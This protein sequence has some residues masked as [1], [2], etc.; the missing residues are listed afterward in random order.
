[1]T[2]IYADEPKINVATLETEVSCEDARK[3]V[4]T[5]G[6][7]SPEEGQILLMKITQCDTKQWNTDHP[8]DPKVTVVS[9]SAEGKILF[10]TISIKDAEK[11]RD[12]AKVIAGAT[13]I[14]ELGASDPLTMTI[15]T[16][17]GDYTVDAYFDAAKKSDPLI[18]VFPTLIPGNKLTTDAL[19][20]LKLK[21]PAEVTIQ[22]TE[23]HL[24]KH[25][26]DLIAPTVT[27]PTREAVKV[28]K[29]IFEKW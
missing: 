19:V 14:A 27:V 29:K 1:M 20:A 3:R 9:E 11:I 21:K 12:A 24:K 15:V 4:A 26:E 2:H 22:K 6:Y 18:I 13:L 7:S 28:I 16:A 17:G 8:E 25:P 10:N 23:E 5:Q